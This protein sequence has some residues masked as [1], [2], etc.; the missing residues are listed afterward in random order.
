MRPNSNCWR[1]SRVSDLSQ[2][3]PKV[4]FR[5]TC[6]GNYGNR[7]CR[8]RWEA[9]RWG[10]FES[11]IERPDDNGNFAGQELIAIDIT[12]QRLLEAQLRHQA[13]T[14]SLTGLANHRR[15]F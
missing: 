3:V 6:P 4:A 11:Q 8:S 5:A 13:S 1:E 2:F 14:D 12:E 9:P 15:L 7:A 10:G